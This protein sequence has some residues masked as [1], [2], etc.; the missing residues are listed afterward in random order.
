MTRSPISKYRHIPT[1]NIKFSKFLELLFKSKMTK[2]DIRE[3]IAKYVQVLE[4][5]YNDTIKELRL[6]FERERNKLR[7]Y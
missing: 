6:Q 7:K 1:E 5:N 3:E 4:T 2:D